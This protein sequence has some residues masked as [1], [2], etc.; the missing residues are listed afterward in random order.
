MKQ[1]LPTLFALLLLNANA[2]WQ[3]TNLTNV[4]YLSLSASES[5]DGELFAIV[6]NGL[7]GTLYKLDAGN[8]SWTAQSVNGVSD[9][10]AFLQSANDRLYL[11][12]NGLG[13]SVLYY[14]EDV[15]ATTVVDT[16]GLPQVNGGIAQI[17]GTQYNDGDLVVNL[18]SEGYWIKTNPNATWYYM[19]TPT[20]LN[21][22]VDPMVW[23]N[24]TYFGFEGSGTT[25]LYSSSDKGITWNTVTNN[26]PADF[27]VMMA[28]ADQASGT[29]FVAGSW[30]SD[31]DYGLYYSA[32]DG[33]TWAWVDLTAFMDMNFLG[34][35]QLITAIYAHDDVIFIGLENDAQM[36]VP[37]VISSSTGVSGFAVNTNGLPTNASG[38]VNPLEFLE[39][40]G[41]IVCRLNV[42]DVFLQEISTGISENN[43]ISAFVQVFPN[44]TKDQ[45]RVGMT[46]ASRYEI[47]DLRGAIVYHGLLLNDVIDVSRLTSGQYLVRLQGKDQ[48]WMARFTKE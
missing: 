19:D 21:G 37:D 33:A 7:S 47:L 27:D 1:L 48:Q 6:F 26:L 8:T 22:G 38:V 11:G 17:Y 12:S 9:N 31:N 25:A 41:N 39:H 42:I 32:D 44:P 13:Y 40:N 15:G 30:N 34:G 35:P 2:Q 43:N 14:T 5:H 10:L 46:D 16:V 3:P 45:L 4:N 20:G 24:G 23:M 18:G 36:T 29:L 28:A